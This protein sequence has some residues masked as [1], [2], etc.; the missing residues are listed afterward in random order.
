MSK[1]RSGC[2]DGRTH[3][4]INGVATRNLPR[5][6]KTGAAAVWGERCTSGEREREREKK[7]SP[8][9]FGTNGQTDRST[10]VK[11]E[12]ISQVILVE[13]KKKWGLGSRNKYLL[14][15]LFA[16]AYWWP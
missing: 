13:E 5:L 3:I 12:Y 9:V 11:L 1:G 4:R 7:I 16:F 6:Y 15:T 10:A 8:A 2:V 14:L